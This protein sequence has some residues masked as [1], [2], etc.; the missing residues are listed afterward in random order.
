MEDDDIREGFETLLGSVPRGFQPAVESPGFLGGAP[1]GFQPALEPPGYL[2]SVPRGFQ[3]AVEPPGFHGVSKQR[4]QEPSGGSPSPTGSGGGAPARM[5]ALSDCA[6]DEAESEEEDPSWQPGKKGEIGR[7]GAKIGKGLGMSGAVAKRS[8]GKR[9]ERRN[10]SPVLQKK[11]TNRQDFEATR[12][13]EEAG[14]TLRDLLG[15]WEGLTVESARRAFEQLNGWTPDEG[16]LRS[17]CVD[18]RAWYRVKFEKMLKIERRFVRYPGPNKLEY[19]WERWNSGHVS[20]KDWPAGRSEEQR[21][22]DK[23]NEGGTSEPFSAAVADVTNWKDRDSALQLKQSVEI[24]VSVVP[25]ATPLL[26]KRAAGSTPK[27]LRPLPLHPGGRKRKKESTN[28]AGASFLEGGS[29][30]RVKPFFFRSGLEVG[31]GSEAEAEAEGEDGA[32]ANTEPGVAEGGHESSLS[33]R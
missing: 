24:G 5:C 15:G 18:I 33:E 23:E 10:L 8:G 22:A 16:M 32:T 27:T 30:T 11:P 31:K 28:E 20:C 4:S 14:R 7:R 6:S 25:G 2:G 21:E 1:R 19:R 13:A 17:R 9:S 26:T 29:Q 12:A 3:P